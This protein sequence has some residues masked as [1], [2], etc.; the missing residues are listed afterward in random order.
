MA[1]NI[2]NSIPL[3][4]DSNYLVISAIDNKYNYAL[5]SFSSAKRLHAKSI[6]FVM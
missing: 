5:L 4:N 3:S 2:V 6:A 1:Q